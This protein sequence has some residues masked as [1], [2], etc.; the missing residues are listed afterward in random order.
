MLAFT[1]YDKSLQQVAAHQIFSG[2][3][4]SA[5]DV[6]GM[7]LGENTLVILQPDQSGSSAFSGIWVDKAGNASAPFHV[8][9]AGTLQFLLGGGLVQGIGGTFV[10][11]WSDGA[12]T[13]SPLPSWLAARAT[14]RLFPIR[15]GAGYAMFGTCGGIEVLTTDGASC[16][17]LPV[18]NLGSNS[19]IGRDG[20]LIVPNGRHFELYPLLFH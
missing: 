17:C 19:S 1:R 3:P 2:G 20:S 9:R 8:D 4:Q 6:I 18:P 12:T 13:Q 5:L 15:A 11:V 10:Q 16:G 7:T 14:G